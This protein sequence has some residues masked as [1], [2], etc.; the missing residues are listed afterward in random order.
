MTRLLT[1]RNGLIL[2]VITMIALAL[3]FMSGGNE[4]QIR[5]RLYALDQAVDMNDPEPLLLSVSAATDIAAFFS[6]N[7]QIDIGHP[8]KVATTRGD[9]RSAIARIRQRAKYIK[10][11]IQ[12]MEV[13]MGDDKSTAVV[14]LM[15]EG[16]ID[17]VNR[18]GS[19]FREYDI[20]MSKI[21]GE[22]LIDKI[23]HAPSITD[24]S[25]FRM[26]RP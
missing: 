26:P 18:R 10:V 4:A 2:T 25:E 9:F 24:P 17:A 11:T 5:K 7:A 23:Q 15:L 21:K 13:L 22:W 8:M 1:P 16:K 19:E 12:G 3:A 20:H 6:E 14:E